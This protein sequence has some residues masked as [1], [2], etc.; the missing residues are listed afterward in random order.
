M[1]H[2]E[3]T[4]LKISLAKKGKPNGHLGMKRS[5]KT[6]DKMSEARLGMKFTEEHCKNLSKAKIGIGL[7]SKTSEETKEKIRQA[8]YRR[9]EKFGYIVHPETIRKS[10]IA[11]QKRAVFHT[12]ETRKKISEALKGSKSHLWRGGITP[13]NKKIRNS[14]EYRLWR[15]SVFKRDDFT[16][17]LCSKRGGNL[18]AHHIKSFSKFPDLRFDID[19]G[20][21]LCIPCHEKVDKHRK[22]KGQEYIKFDIKHLK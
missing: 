21:T 10:I 19:N 14:L 18:E 11:R 6:K 12:E 2:S 7:G 22:I 13:L 4:K 17:C 20:Q 3:E 16:C 5:Q 8:A 1:A 15:E 9:K